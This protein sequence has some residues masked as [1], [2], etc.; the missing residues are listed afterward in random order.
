MAFVAAV[1]A[2]ACMCCT[3][4]FA[5]NPPVNEPQYANSDD[6]IH[7]TPR[8]NQGTTDNE[9]VNSGET[10]SENTLGEILNG[11]DYANELYH[12]DEFKPS[13]I[14]VSKTMQPIIGFV[15][16]TV[17]ILCALFS[18]MNLIVM[19]VD[20]FC[21]SFRSVNLWVSHFGWQLFSDTCAEIT[22]IR[23]QPGRG[24]QQG[25]GGSMAGAPAQPVA[26]A[27]PAGAPA[28]QAGGGGMAN[29]P[30]SSKL[31]YWFQQ[32]MVR[33]ILCG[34]LLISIAI[35]LA[36]MLINVGINFL[37][38]GGFWILQKIKGA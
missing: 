24:N 1:V 18:V 16:T 3:V 26:G 27:Q 29:E 15:S 28:G 38:N 6:E 17:T 21:I 2:C 33:N 37:V 12:T 32:T 19:V 11:R 20:I 22:G 23:H 5:D 13:N 35:G 7:F 30:L 4:A 34:A 31:G 8:Q 10:S 14:D 25:A 9:A 36:P